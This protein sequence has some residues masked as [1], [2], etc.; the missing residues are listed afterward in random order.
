MRNIIDI[1]INDIEKSIGGKN[2]KM[3]V[4]LRTINDNSN[5]ICRLSSSEVKLPLIVRTRKMGDRISVKGLIGTKKVKDI[6]ID[7]KIEKKSRDI[8]PIVVD[9][10]GRIVWIPGLK[11]S[12]FD[13]KDEESY[14][15]ILKYC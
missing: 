9:S 2:E 4:I 12:K 7:N 10:L 13:K 15:I 3:K 6:F 11:K 5:F 1:E 14:D 8:W